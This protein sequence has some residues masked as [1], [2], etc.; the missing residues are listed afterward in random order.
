MKAYTN[1]TDRVDKRKNLYSEI[2]KD[3]KGRK[4]ANRKSAKNEID[5]QVIEH[6]DNCNSFYTA[7]DKCLNKFNNYKNKKDER[8]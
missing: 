3:D 6:G 1:K 4:K 5:K 7:C 2:K 8:I